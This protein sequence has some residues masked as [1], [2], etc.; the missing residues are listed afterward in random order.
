MADPKSLPVLA[1]E[2]AYTAFGEMEG[3]GRTPTPLTPHEMVTDPGRTSFPSRCLKSLTV[4]RRLGD[5]LSVARLALDPVVL[6]IALHALA[7]L[8]RLNRV[9]HDF[10][11]LLLLFLRPGLRSGV[12]RM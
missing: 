11:V 6:D 1:L 5:T 8:R 12:W 10:L 3:G 9:V 2:L 4:G 7:V